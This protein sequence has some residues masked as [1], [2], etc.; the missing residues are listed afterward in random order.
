MTI[1]AAHFQ[2]HWHWTFPSKCA[3]SLPLPHLLHKMHASTCLCK[4]HILCDYLGLW[5]SELKN[6]YLEIHSALAWMYP[7]VRLWKCLSS[8][9]GGET[10]KSRAINRITL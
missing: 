4:H 9:R 6:I 7:S 2:V 1:V 5:K 10:C 3:H 8:Q